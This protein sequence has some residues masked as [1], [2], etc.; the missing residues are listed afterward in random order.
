MSSDLLMNINIK[1]GFNDDGTNY[2]TYDG[3]FDSES[4]LG[5]ARSVA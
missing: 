4:A 2:S 3:V 5:Y 1:K